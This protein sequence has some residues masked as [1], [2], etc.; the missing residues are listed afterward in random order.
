M[1]NVEDFI[2]QLENDQKE[3]MLY[4]HELL[5]HQLELEDRIR[6][7]I[8]FYYHKSWVCYLNPIKKNAVELAF[9]FGQELSNQ[10]GLLEA[11]G[12]KQV[13]GIR[14]SKVEEIPVDLVYEVIQE[15]LMLD[16]MKYNKRKSK[17]P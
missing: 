2:S 15:A 6:F 9:L 3:I 12:R 10:Q 17:S 8:P 4:F 5:A 7:K 11:N 13:A 14:F 16:E 1:G